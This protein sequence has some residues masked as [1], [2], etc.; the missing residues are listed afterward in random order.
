MQTAVRVD[1][2]AV[3]MRLLIVGAEAEATRLE[4]TLTMA[5]T[6][7]ADVV[8]VNPDSP[9][10]R[11]DYLA[12][13]CWPSRS[14]IPSAD[15]SALSPLRCRRRSFPKARASKRIGCPWPPRLL[16]QAGRMPGM[17]ACVTGVVE[18]RENGAAHA[19]RAALDSAAEAHQAQMNLTNAPQRSIR[20]GPGHLRGVFDRDRGGRLPVSRP[21][22][23]SRIGAAASP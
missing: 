4:R 16:V 19:V 8:P 18:G 15:Q 3:T 2:S 21:L 14:P 20:V 5:V 17:V 11:R 12:G 13:G 1:R 7:T 6:Q 10:P 22:R 9:P 23:S